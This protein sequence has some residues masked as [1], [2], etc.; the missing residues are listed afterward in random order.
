ML[1]IGGEFLKAAMTGAFPG[2]QLLIIGEESASTPAGTVVNMPV[3]YSGPGL[4]CPESMSI[5]ALQATT[6]GTSLTGTVV[7]YEVRTIFTDRLL[8]R[9]AFGLVNSDT[10][11]TG[12]PDMEDGLVVE[13]GDGFMVTL[14]STAGVNRYFYVTIMGTEYI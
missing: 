6:G 5:Q 4:F 12:W 3:I 2:S 14:L 7:S 11:T 9:Q 13:N 10:L 1:G 8:Q